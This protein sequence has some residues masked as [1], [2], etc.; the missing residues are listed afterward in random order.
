[1]KFTTIVNFKG[2]NSRVLTELQKDEHFLFHYVGRMPTGNGFTDLD[3]GWGKEVKTDSWKLKQTSTYAVP[4]HTE[5]YTLGP[6]EAVMDNNEEVTDE[7]A[8][9]YDRYINE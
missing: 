8:V 4:V 1:M 2:N 6:Y 5:I 9:V 3:L 7:G